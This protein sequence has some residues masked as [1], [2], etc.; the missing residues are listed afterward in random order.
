[1]WNIQLSVPEIRIKGIDIAEFYFDRKI[2]ADN[3]F[4]K[5]P[6]IKLY[7]KQKNT[8]QKDI[9]EINFPLPKEI[10]SISLRQFTLSNGLLKVFSEI[11]TK[12][13]LV[14]QSA[15][16]M[17]AQ[18]IL[19]RKDP[20]AGKPEFLKGSYTGKLIQF[21]FTPKD[22]N[23][24]FSVD[25][26]SF[27]TKEQ[28]IM[29]T[30]LVVKA[31][32]KSQT[33]DQFELRIPNLS[34]NGLNIDNAY[35]K[36]QYNFESILIDG[37]VFQLFNNAKDSVRFNPFGINLYP[38]FESFADEFSS[39]SIQVKN[40]DISVFKNGNKTLQEILNFNLSNV[41]IDKNPSPGFMHS[42]NFSF[43]IPEV[44]RKSKLYQYSVG[45]S[46][47]SSISNYFIAKDIR[48]IPL[49]NRGK[50]QQ[51]SVFQSDYFTGKI[52]SVRILQPDIRRWFD[53]KE[54]VGKSMVID[55]LNLGI[56][57]D[58]RT[59]FNE[60]QR[61]K[62]VQDLIKSIKYPVSVDSLIINK[63]AVTYSELLASGD[64]EGRIGFTRIQAQ[65]APFTNMKLASGT[66]PDISMKG[67]TTIMDSCRLTV[68]MNFKMNSQ[69][70][71]FTAKG[72][73]SEFNMHIL[74]PVIEPLAMVSLRSGHVD[75]FEFDLTGNN[76]S[77]SGQ[78]FFGYND[79]KI[80]LLEMKNGNTREA[81]FN[82]FLANSLMLRSKNPRG[83]ELLPAEISFI[84]DQKR[85]D[86]NYW[87]KSVFS[88]V[89]NTLGINK[90]N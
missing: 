7:Q 56:F 76:T 15:I 47:Y 86:L 74:N 55:A 61:P 90:E 50:Y 66:I 16:S 54:I 34:L 45:E 20:N 82:S 52:D 60:N 77:S 22:K 37:P 88:G 79:F 29:A 33:D 48:I 51:Q 62:M 44:K 31:K 80:S 10:E 39:K 5:A 78:L 26:L 14:V 41:K 32:I 59:P 12:P 2:D 40:A 11:E 64:T 63:S 83:K 25:E 85:S 3:L 58:K 69:D 35:K 4:I 19:T 53:K 49:Y 71:F 65:I 21:K 38:H 42:L 8:N 89:R 1:M 6:D 27:S 68:N 17:E 30:N 75:R 13:Y 43:R 70:N 72:K 24:Q 67:A 23:Q 36:Y 87:W 46:S 81:R 9:K 57:R 18:D 28:K 84:K 73:L